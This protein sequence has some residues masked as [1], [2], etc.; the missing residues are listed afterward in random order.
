MLQIMLKT[1]FA[2]TQDLASETTQKRHD[3]GL[4][5][6]RLPVPCTFPSRDSVQFARVA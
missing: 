3:A 1:C 5:A 4:C 2:A 6:E